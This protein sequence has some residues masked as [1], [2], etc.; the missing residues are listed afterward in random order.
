MMEDF[1]LGELG[2]TMQRFKTC[3]VI[4]YM[5]AAGGYWRNW[6]RQTAWHS[7]EI[8]FELI[9]GNP[10]YKNYDKPRRKG[11]IYNLST[12]QK[13]EEDKPEDIVKEAKEYEAQ[14]KDKDHAKR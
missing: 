7:R 5:K 10:Y 4:E 12:D 14:L 9:R 8:I 3:T 2:W 13:E 6:E 11:E 1:A